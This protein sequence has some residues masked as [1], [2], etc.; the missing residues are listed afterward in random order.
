MMNTVRI[1]KGFTPPD[2]QPAPFLPGMDDPILV[3]WERNKFVRA[4]AREFRLQTRALAVESQPKFRSRDDFTLE[5]EFHFDADFAPLDLQIDDIDVDLRLGGFHAQT[6][7]SFVNLEAPEMHQPRAVLHPQP[8]AKPGRGRRNPEPLVKDEVVFW[9]DAE[10]L[11][12]KHELIAES[13]QALARSKNADEKA[14]VL[15]WM[16]GNNEDDAMSD[17]S[18]ENVCADLNMDAHAIRAKLVQHMRECVPSDDEIIFTF[19]KSYK[20]YFKNG[21]FTERTVPVK[22]SLDLTDSSYPLLELETLDRTHKDIVPACFTSCLVRRESGRS[23]RDEVKPE[24][25]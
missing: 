5:F 22:Y 9:T 19:A 3:E 23:D 13:L 1:P 6:Q 11:V 21:K 8:R 24:V 16:F 18:F 25:L 10:E 17:Y 4:A 7:V 2:Y 12:M 20:H 15:V 14:D